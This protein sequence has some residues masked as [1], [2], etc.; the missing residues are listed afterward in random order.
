MS[1]WERFLDSPVCLPAPRQ[2]GLPELG[3]DTFLPL[4]Y[5]AR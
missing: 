3:L 2:A 1:T 5:V 4:E